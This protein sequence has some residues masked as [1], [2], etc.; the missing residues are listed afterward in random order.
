MKKDKKPDALALI[1][2][3]NFYDGTTHK[4]IDGYGDSIIDFCNYECSNLVFSPYGDLFCP[5]VSETK[6]KFLKSISNFVISLNLNKI[7]KKWGPF[8]CTWV[9]GK[10]AAHLGSWGY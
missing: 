5:Y 6:L 2:N 3:Y 9:L 4:Q 10:L 1:D 7:M 8:A